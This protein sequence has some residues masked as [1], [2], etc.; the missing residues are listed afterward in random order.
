MWGQIHV[1]Y[2]LHKNFNVGFASHKNDIH[3]YLS[4]WQYWWWF[5]FAVVWALYFFIILKCVISKTSNFNFIQNTSLRS[6]GKWGDFLI[7]II[8]LSWCGNILINSNFILRMIEWQNESSLFTIRIQGKQWYWV[9][10]YNSDTNAKLKNIYINVGNNNW[11]KNNVYNNYFFIINN[12]ILTYS[13][14]YE[15]KQ[16][17]NF[18][19]SKKDKLNNNLIN[20]NYSNN[21]NL[22]NFKKLNIINTKLY[23]TL[24]LKNNIKFRNLFL[25]YKNTSLNFYNL[26]NNDE[27]FN[28]INNIKVSNIAQNV[29]YKNYNLFDIKLNKF[30]VTNSYF[31]IDKL[32]EVDEPSETLRLKNNNFPIKL[33]K[34]VLNKHNN[35]ILNTNY[36]LNKNILLNYRI[37]TKNVISRNSQVEQF[38]GFRQKKNKKLKSSYF[39]FYN[40]Y[41]S[42]TF[43]N[44]INFVNNDNFKKYNLYANIKNNKYKSELI[45]LNLTKRLLRTKRTLVLP[46][47]VNLT[48]ITGSYDVVHSWFVPGLGL[49]MDCV[50]GRSTHHSLYIDNVGFYYG[51][52]AEIC[53]R[54]HHHMPIRI[55]ALNFEHFIVWWN[56]K[57]L[58]RMYRSKYFL[59]NKHSILNKLN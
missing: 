29:I 25:N 36:F 48:L 18:I 52:C 21:L 11:V 9:Y 59:E 39:S 4:Q 33:F 13:F 2:H 10:K 24:N 45:P 17:Y 16:L 20:L 30:N 46:A 15:F 12:S 40:K 7:A 51:Q 14:E 58:A 43:D 26:K 41:H 56:H 54:Y 6:H 31:E 1:D 50:P 44:I 53:G 57:G 35:S 28:L 42:K 8:P 34:G 27:S 47:H 55:C 38:W 23:Y 32:D 19:L 3:V 22:I 5:W 37:N 49:K